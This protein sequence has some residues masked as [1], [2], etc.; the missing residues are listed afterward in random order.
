MARILVSSF[1]TTPNCTRPADSCNFGVIEKLT[2]ARYFQIALETMLLYIQITFRLLSLG[3]LQ[4]VLFVLISLELPIL[5]SEF[6]F[7]AAELTSS[8]EKR[9]AKKFSFSCKLFK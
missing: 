8:H 2:R 1:S 4:S 7:I 3:L 6:R 5:A 9:Y